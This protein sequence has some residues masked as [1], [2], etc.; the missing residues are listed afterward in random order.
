MTTVT[1]QPAEL[2]LP[3]PQDFPEADVVIFD[4]QCRF[5][6]RQVSRLHYWDGRQRLAF[7]S[8]HDSFVAEQYPDLSHDQLMEQMYLV[9]QSGHRHG[10]AEAFR[11][12]TRRLPI[13]WILAPLLHLPF[14]LPLWRWGYKQV[15]KRRYRWGKVDDC[16]SGSCEVHFK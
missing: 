6:R 7:I 2:N 8:L 12:L 10:G 5:C 9:D 15:A 11:Y 1:S 3:S 14:S 16:A 13:L 4:G